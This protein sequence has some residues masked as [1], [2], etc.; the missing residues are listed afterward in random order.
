VFGLQIFLDQLEATP[1]GIAKEPH[2]VGRRFTV[3][4]LSGRFA[5]RFLKRFLR[6]RRVARHE[7]AKTVELREILIRLEQG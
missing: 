4:G 1:A 3:G 7:E 6:L 5:Q 2:A